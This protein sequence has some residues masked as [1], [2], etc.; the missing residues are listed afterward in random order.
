VIALIVALVLLMAGLVLSTSDTRGK[1]VS[2]RPTTEARTEHRDPR[3][4]LRISDA[5]VRSIGR[6]AYLRKPTRLA[7]L[8][9]TQRYIERAIIAPLER[10]RAI[11]GW[12]KVFDRR[13]RRIA[14]KRDLAKVTEV[15]M[16]FRDKH[17]LA[18]IPRVRAD[19]VGSPGGRIAIVALTW[20]MKVTA[21]T[22]RGPLT[23]RRRTELTYARDHGR[24]QVTG[25]R[26]GVTRH[27]A[28]PNRR[29]ATARA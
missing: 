29:A 13:T 2:R 3:R 19:A 28:K 20:S 24:W 12:A 7:V 23:I 18:S 1:A 25:Y 15:K 11:P 8:R 10:G 27:R 17:V 22:G 9:K 21:D 26:L 16:G 14:R 5:H 4:G 6:R